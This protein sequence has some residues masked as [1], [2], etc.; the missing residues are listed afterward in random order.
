MYMYIHTYICTY[1]H[2]HTHTQVLHESDRQKRGNMQG[3]FSTAGLS[4]KPARVRFSQVGRDGRW[5]RFDLWLTTY[6]QYG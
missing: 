5:P 1:I 6:G 4:H 2:T 3:G